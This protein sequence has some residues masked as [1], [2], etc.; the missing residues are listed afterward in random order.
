MTTLSTSSSTT[1]LSATAR[2]AKDAP[3]VTDF[4]PR[5]HQDVAREGPDF[6]ARMQREAGDVVVFPLGKYRWIQVSHPD[7]VERICRQS[8]RTFDKGLAWQN[9]RVLAGNGL[10]STEPRWWATHRQVL[11]PAFLRCYHERFAQRVSQS[12]DETTA[13]WRAL[14]AGTTLKIVDEMSH[15]TLR[16]A[17]HTLFGVEWKDEIAQISQCVTRV[18]DYL[19]HW[20]EYPLHKRLAGRYLRRTVHARFGRDLRTLEKLAQNVVSQRQKLPRTN[21]INGQANG[22]EPDDVLRL[23]L[24]A[25]DDA[26]RQL[27]RKMN[28]WQRARF[29]RDNILTFIF[30]GHETTSICASWTFHLLAQH[31]EVERKLHDELDRVLDGRTPTRDDL[32]HLPY[33]KQVVLESLRLYPPVWIFVR[34]TTQEENIGGYTLPRGSML[35]IQPYVVHRHADFWPEPERFDPERFAPDTKNAEHSF[36]YIPFGGGPRMCLGR[37]TALIEAQLI[38]AGLAQHFQLRSAPDVEIKPLASMTLLPSHGLPMI[39]CKR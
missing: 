36:A 19:N 35:N 11:Q 21:E 18:L 8:H 1:P 10:I 24:R 6:Y 32:P 4:A 30:T 13:H 33:L 17:G 39:L 27:G 37:Q 29:L 26:S 28:R 7:D 25:L 23:L 34:Q 3:R 2:N 16:N 9:F 38:V 15:L 12:V 5:W 14:P 31:P 20:Y 22:E